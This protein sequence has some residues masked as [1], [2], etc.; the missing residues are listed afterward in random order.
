MNFQP[1][2]SYPGTKSALAT[3]TFLQ[4]V[5]LIMSAGLSITGLM[6]WLF[7]SLIQDPVNIIKPEYGFLVQS[8]M[9]WVISLAPLVFV[10][11]ISGL[12]NRINYGMA[13]L[14]FAVYSLLMGLS[15]SFIFL[16]YTTESVA[17]TFFITG[18]TFGAMALI[19]MTTKMDLSRMGSFL[20]MALIGIIIASVVNI[21]IGSSLMATVISALGV[22]IF[23][24]LTA[25]DTQKLM[26]IGMSVDA[27]SE[28]G[29]KA[30]LMGALTLYLDFI[31]LFLFL[32][33]FVGNRRD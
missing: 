10:F 23:C 27:D 18:G 19:G 17:S 1:S 9:I 8:P 24:G 11:L 16:V 33:R 25:Y 26:H 22:L 6:S 15:L 13:T 7:Y 14:L 4:R 12:I 2:Q 31:N 28:M 20:M 29:R 30:A 21:F 32:L 5:Y 3:N